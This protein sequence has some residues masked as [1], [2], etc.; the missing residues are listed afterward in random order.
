[1]RMRQA[2]EHPTQHLRYR[3]DQTTVVWEQNL[4]DVSTESKAR[5]SSTC[6]SWLNMLG[7]PNISFAKRKLKDNLGVQSSDKP[8]TSLQSP[9]SN[10]FECSLLQPSGHPGTQY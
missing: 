8:S 9:E 4:E 5:A 10:E 3:N 7:N 2:K 6:S 1:M